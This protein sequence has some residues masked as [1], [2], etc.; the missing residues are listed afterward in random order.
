MTELVGENG[1][2]KTQV[3]L[4]L[5]LETV[6][7]GSFGRRRPQ[8]RHHHHRRDGDDE[9]G[10]EE[11]DGVSAVYVTTEGQF[12][13]ERLR[14]MWRERRRIQ[15]EREK[16]R[17][18]DVRMNECDNEEVARRKR[19]EREPVSYTHLTLPTKRIV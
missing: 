8:N 17:N 16:E 6:G 4:Q 14:E 2:G 3:C 18:G 12:P 15:L 7:G 13:V 19:A 10:E 1:S 11:D 5:L 9:D